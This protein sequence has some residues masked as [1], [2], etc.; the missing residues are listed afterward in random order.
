MGL[1]EGRAWVSLGGVGHVELREGFFGLTANSQRKINLGKN[2]MCSK[3]QRDADSSIS[4]AEASMDY[5][6]LTLQFILLQCIRGV[7]Y[8]KLQRGNGGSNLS[9]LKEFGRP[10]VNVFIL[11]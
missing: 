3:G 7:P 9:F 10:R 11:K 8:I 1:N 6:F 2:I 5:S 4:K